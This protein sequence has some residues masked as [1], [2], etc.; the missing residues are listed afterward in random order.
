VEAF[1]MTTIAACFEGCH[2]KSLSHGITAWSWDD[3][4][5]HPQGST[6]ATPWLLPHLLFVPS[7]FQFEEKFSS[8]DVRRGNILVNNPTGQ[9]I[10]HG[11]GYSHLV[12]IVPGYIIYFISSL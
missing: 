10:K 4:S 12:C 7:L 5:S 2:V 8:D 1:S 3:C 9:A 6:H 11:F